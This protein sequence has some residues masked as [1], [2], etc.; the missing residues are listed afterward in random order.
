MV[1][2]SD[3]ALAILSAPGI[4][5]G[6][7]KRSGVLGK[8]FGKSGEDDKMTFDRHPDGSG[9]FGGSAEGDAANSQ[10]RW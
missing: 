9:V 3:D 4:V 8:Y 5:V 7:A 1:G 10:D 6:D 2:D